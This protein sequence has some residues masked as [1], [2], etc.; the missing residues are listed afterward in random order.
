M[1]SETGTY[2]YTSGHLSFDRAG[3]RIILPKV[4][5]R[6]LNSIVVVHGDDDAKSF[7]IHRVSDDSKIG[8]T[9]TTSVW[10][11]PVPVA[12]FSPHED[13]ACYLSV[14]TE[15]TSI[16]Q[17]YLYYTSSS[18]GADA[19]QLGY[20]FNYNTFN[21]DKNGDVYT[22][23]GTVAPF[24]GINIRQKDLPT[25]LDTYS[26]TQTVNEVTY[27][28]TSLKPS[29]GYTKGDLYC[30]SGGLWSG[31]YG[32]D[33]Y[34]KRP[35]TGKLVWVRAAVGNATDGSNGRL[36]RIDARDQGENGYETVGQGVYLGATA[37]GR[38][39]GTSP[40]DNAEFKTWCLKDSFSPTKDYYLFCGN[41]YTLIDEFVLIYL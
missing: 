7:E 25:A 13:E 23:D 2:K 3:G 31:Q 41:G 19:V 36:I 40:S 11:I 16:A 34:L 35:R 18:T 30:W 33:K 4:K 26:F 38:K 8:V 22:K 5:N 27:T 12:K 39:D 1:V 15:N 10:K 17:I 14:L 6:Y 24:F 32:N 29:E 37:Y 20:E 28:F 21:Q 9:H